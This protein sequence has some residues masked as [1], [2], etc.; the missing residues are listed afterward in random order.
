MSRHEP[1]AVVQRFTKQVSASIQALG[2]A[3]HRIV[4]A[5]SGGP[6]STALLRAL[7]SLKR[8]KK[9]HLAAV[10]VNHALRGEESKADEHFVIA[11]CERHGIPLMHH[12]LPVPLDA[13]DRDEGI[14]ATARNL[15]Q[16]FFA[17]AARQLNAPF[18]ATAHTADDQA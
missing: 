9:L 14:E 5:V 6:D 12:R 1:K 17:E 3:T 16:Q 18:V 8:Q 2:A 13:A 10:H 11:L 15:R 7:D 4:A